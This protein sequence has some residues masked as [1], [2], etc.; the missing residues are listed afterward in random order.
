MEL[1]PADLA[2]D[3][4]SANAVQRCTPSPIAPRPS[5][6]RGLK[7][8]F[9]RRNV[10]LERRE[11]LLPL[12]HARRPLDQRSHDRPPLAKFGQGVGR[13]A[14]VLVGQRY[15]GVADREIALPAAVAGI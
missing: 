4:T 2:R 5:L 14:E 11:L 13:L 1:L 9:E 6:L 3:E 15:E 12:R 10:A 8:T 7:L